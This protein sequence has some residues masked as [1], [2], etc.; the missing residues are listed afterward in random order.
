ME[1]SRLTISRKARFYRSQG[2]IKP[3]TYGRIRPAERNITS[4]SVTKIVF[5]VI[6]IIMDQ[7]HS[8][9]LVAPATPGRALLTVF[10][11]STFP[12]ITYTESSTQHRSFPL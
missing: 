4:N 9:A 12:Y 1:R 5:M 10:I 11:P 3:R 8:P 2:S 6:Y 7:K